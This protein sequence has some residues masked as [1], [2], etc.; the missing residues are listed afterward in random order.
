VRAQ[1]IRPAYMCGEQVGDLS[2]VEFRSLQDKSESVVTTSYYFEKALGE[3]SLNGW[4]NPAA[5]ALLVALLG[6]VVL[7]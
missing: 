4:A 1:D 7:R 5:I 2:T 3:K 6:V